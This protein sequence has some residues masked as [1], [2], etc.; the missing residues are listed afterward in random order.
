MSLSIQARSD[1][2]DKFVRLAMQE[3]GDGPFDGLFI[4]ADAAPYS[5]IRPTT[6]EEAKRRRYVKNQGG[7][8][9]NLQ[10]TVGLEGSNC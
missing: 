9:I 5:E 2:L 6:W 8:H 3:L 4:D 10:K 1:D 7:K